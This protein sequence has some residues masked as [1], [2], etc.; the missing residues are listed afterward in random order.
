MVKTVYGRDSTLLNDL[1]NR[2][3]EAENYLEAHWAPKIL[4]GFATLGERALHAFPYYGNY[5]KLTTLELK[6]FRSVHPNHISHVMFVGA[7]PCRM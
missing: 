1:R 6:L 5:A 7:G 4:A 3:A 2:C